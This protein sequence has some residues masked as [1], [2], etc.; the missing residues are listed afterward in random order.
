VGFTR[1]LIA[2][3]LVTRLSD[4][5]Q[6]ERLRRSMGEQMEI[7]EALSLVAEIARGDAE[8]KTRHAA[9]RTVLE[10]H[11]VL[12]GAPRVDRRESMRAIHSLVA[13]IKEKVAGGARVRV[14]ASEGVTTSETVIEA[15]VVE[16]EGPHHKDEKNEDT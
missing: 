3:K 7:D 4:L 13:A 8:S 12:T 5:I 16:S 1:P 15:E 10:V 14:R 2:E 9:L 11:G 6:A